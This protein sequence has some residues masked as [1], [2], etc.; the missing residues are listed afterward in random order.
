MILG[1]DWPRLHAALNDLPAAL[2]TMCVLFELA[3]WALKRESL[4]WAAIWT[5]WA[6]VLGGWLAVIAGEQAED[7]IEHGEGIHELMETHETLALTTM[8]VFTVILVWRMWRRFKTSALEDWVLRG[9]SVAG[10]VLVTWTGVIGGRMM[11][12]HTAGIPVRTM[13]TEIEDRAKGHHHEAGEGDEHGP[14]AARPDTAH[15]H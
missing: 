8:A 11:F 12:E 10:L 7:V 13:R 15:T 1:Y 4:R 14:P 2:L 3:G 9:L 6:G 5:L